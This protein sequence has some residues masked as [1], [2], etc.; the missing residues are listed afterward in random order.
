MR[1]SGCVRL[2]AL[3]SAALL[4]FQASAL[5]FPLNVEF[6]GALSPV[7]PPPW[8]VATFTD[9]SPDTVRLSLDAT[10][11][12]DAEFVSEWMF[13]VNESFIGGLSFSKV[14]GVGTFDDPVIGQA[15]DNF[16]ADGDGDFDIQFAFETAEAGRF[17]A[18]ELVAYNITATGLT[19]ADF[20]LVSDPRGGKGI[21]YSAAHVQA[22][23]TP[24]GTT[25]GSGWIGAS[26]FSVP[27][28]SM[29][30]MLLGMALLSVEWMRRKLGRH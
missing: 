7:G 27:D 1:H 24:G 13:N 14:G 21:Y 29:T 2:A 22:I 3:G 11:L 17:G 25:G 12:S 10:G 16:G 23:A 6:S 4:S 5:Q 26:T 19:A 18:G 30:A 20:L 28:S 15:L 9:I 8:L